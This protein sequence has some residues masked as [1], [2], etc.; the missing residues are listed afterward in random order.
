[1]AKLAASV[2]IPIAIMKRNSLTITHSRADCGGSAKLSVTGRCQ[3]PRGDERFNPL[4]R[5]W[6]RSAQK[7]LPK[8]ASL[9]RW[10]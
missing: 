4:D 10:A 7:F 6:F 1:M 5:N 9:S 3:L 2:Q 8:G